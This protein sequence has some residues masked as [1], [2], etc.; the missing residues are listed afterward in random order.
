VS[1]DGDMNASTSASTERQKRSCIRCNER[2]IKCDKANPCGACCK[3]GDECLFPPPQRAPRTLNRPPVPELLARLREL[4]SEVERL[5][6]ASSVVNGNTQEP[7]QSE[8]SNST[9]GAASTPEAEPAGHNH[10]APRINEDHAMNENNSKMIKPSPSGFF[11][12]HTCDKSWSRAAFL[13]DYLQPSQIAN[14]WKIY[15]AQVAPVIALLHKPYLSQIFINASNGST[16]EHHEEALF[17]SACFASIVSM[18]PDQCHKE[19]G[20]EYTTSR[21]HFETAVNEAL[22]QSKLIT[23]QNMTTL[24]AAVLYLLSSRLDGNSRRIWAESAVLIRVAQSQKLHRDGQKLGF[25]PF[26]CEIRRR[27]WWHICI[28]DM[29]VSEDQD[30]P[31]QIHP[32]M[33]DT[34]VPTNI[35]DDDLTP[36]MNDVV[37]EQD[38][39]TNITLCIITAHFITELHWLR[40]F[41]DHDENQQMPLEQRKEIVRTLGKYMEEQYLNQFDLNIPI[42]WMTATISRLHLSRA[43]L[44][45][46]LTS[47]GERSEKPD[48]SVN[49]F[50]FRTGVEILEFVHLLQTNTLITSWSW[51]WKSYREWH[52]MAYVISE[53]C[54]RPLDSESNHAWEMVTKMYDQWRGEATTM[55]SEMAKPLARLMQRAVESRAAKMGNTA[56][57]P[58]IPD[59]R[60]VGIEADTR[61]DLPPVMDS[62]TLDVCPMLSYGLDWGHRTSGSQ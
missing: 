5:R 62:S 47:S 6:S 23:S 29:L 7:L 1:R 27:L 16:L 21:Q 52:A 61:I 24:Q 40:D 35:D 53:L 57:S 49:D 55:D 3:S 13:R 25:S 34:A 56:S 31:R 50:L 37:V 2:K 39:F 45:I 54:D 46:Q 22:N 59:A 19:I 20:R 11:D 48:S 58:G 10:D 18:T 8:N 41:Q 4:E 32:I 43:W 17:F 12:F 9:P 14:L 28:L 33:F 51:L 26:K 38:N 42:Q 15:L 30:V 60:G 44:F 36:D